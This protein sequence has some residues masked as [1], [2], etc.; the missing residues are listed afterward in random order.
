MLMTATKGL[1]LAVLTV[2]LLG[3]SGVVLAQTQD[4]KQDKKA[5]ANA[6]ARATAAEAI[7]K[8]LLARWKKGP[9]IGESGSG[10]FAE[11]LYRWSSRWMEAQTEAG[12]KKAEAAAAQSHVD[13]MRELDRIAREQQKLKV[14]GVLDVTAVQFYRLQAEK[15]LRKLKKK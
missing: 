8:G 5:I 15:R 12:D 6:K 14:V 2:L 1:C 9:G 13:R 4:D 3:L 11:K 7:Y 10:D